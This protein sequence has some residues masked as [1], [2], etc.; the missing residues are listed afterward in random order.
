MQYIGQTGRN[1]R[2]RFKEPIRE[3]RNNQDN[4]KYAQHIINITHSCGTIEETMG[5]VKPAKKKNT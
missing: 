2:I 4:S 1:F 3:I 5:V